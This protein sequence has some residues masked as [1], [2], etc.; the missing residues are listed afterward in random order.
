MAV[1]NAR[2]KEDKKYKKTKTPKFVRSNDKTDHGRIRLHERVKDF[3]SLFTVKKLR[4]LIKSGDAKVKKDR[5]G[6][7]LVHIYGWRVV[8]SRNMKSII[9]AYRLNS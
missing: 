6:S 4:K 1:R 2:I 9:S 3:N 7:V 8:L 5:N